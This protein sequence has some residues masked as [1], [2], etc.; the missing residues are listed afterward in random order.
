MAKS[1]VI[2][3]SPAKAKTVNHYLGE[4]YVVKA[5]MGHIR[6][7]PEK[8]LGVDIAAGFVPTYEV[9]PEKKKV[10]ADLRKAAKDSERVILAADPDR[11]GEAI[12]WQLSQL[13]A[14]VNPNIFRA[15]FHEITEEG[16]TAAFAN[17]GQVDASLLD[18]QQTRR[19]LDRLVGYLISPLL[20]KKIS[21]GLSAGR[22]QSVAL[23]L[24]VDRERERQAFKPE[25][26]WNIAA[27]LEAQAPPAFKAPLAKIDGKK[28][29]VGSAEEASAIVAALN[30]LSFIRYHYHSM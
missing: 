14:E 27:C 5:S 18:A 13:L 22:V 2:V 28:A 9:I 20:W 3:E 23:R 26:Y 12:S 6:D 24:I 19:I 1:L 7:L 25:E 15:S 29:A 21:R 17:L 8:K 16:V 10:V 30:V 4:D 11:E